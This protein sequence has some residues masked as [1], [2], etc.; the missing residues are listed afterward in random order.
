MYLTTDSLI[1]AQPQQVAGHPRAEEL[2]GRVRAGA[3]E[4]EP[5]LQAVLGALADEAE[6]RAYKHLHPAG[7]DPMT[8]PLDGGSSY[9]EQRPACKAYATFM[10]KLNMCTDMGFR[11]GQAVTNGDVGLA[12]EALARGEL[13]PSAVAEELLRARSKEMAG[14]LKEYSAPLTGQKLAAM[15]GGNRHP[16][17]TSL[18]YVA[19][20]VDIGVAQ[21]A[22]NHAASHS[23]PNAVERLLAA[24]LPVD[25]D[26]LEDMLD[27]C[28]DGD[29]RYEL[30]SALSRVK[31]AARVLP[32][33]APPAAA[34]KKMPPNVSLLLRLAEAKDIQN[35][36]QLV[37]NHPSLVRELD[38]WV[39]DRD[40][41]L[42]QI[43][44]P[45]PPRFDIRRLEGIVDG[46]SSVVNLEANLACLGA[47]MVF[48]K[49]LKPP[50]ENG[51]AYPQLARLRTTLQAH[52]AGGLEARLDAIV[53]KAE[54][55]AVWA[56]AAPYRGARDGGASWLRALEFPAEA[57]ALLADMK[58]ELLPP[59]DALLGALQ[60]AAATRA[61]LADARLQPAELAAAAF[62]AGTEEVMA[63][64][65]EDARF[66][67]AMMGKALARERGNQWRQAL[68]VA[69]GRVH[70]ATLQAAVDTKDADKVERMVKVVKVSR[71]F[72]EDLADE[73][74]T[75]DVRY[76]L[77]LAARDAT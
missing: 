20:L 64:L 8:M 6:W 73:A 30:E 67:R 47:T 9:R 2:L 16:P 66:D 68:K 59:L 41:V 42:R 38:E 44:A 27:V 43:L 45:P 76:E 5:E 46:E 71:D 35:G 49:D 57:Q 26:M 31:P 10:Y 24:G 75:D 28:V 21:A 36:Q 34:P 4:L 70:E 18:R 1:M 13:A 12:R 32:P 56:R 48:G 17:S 65:V 3:P 62:F 53:A 63:A 25:V 54:D 19:P 23:N 55:P 29:C 22:L 77:Q 58:A 52:Q 61:A 15:A 72:L 74:P 60:D 14:L 11:L 7:G 40:D 51:R 50:T 37:R 39:S 33:P 69:P